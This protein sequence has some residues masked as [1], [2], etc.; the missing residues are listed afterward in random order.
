M[1]TKLTLALLFSCC[2]FYLSAQ[3]E[4]K[5]IQSKL[6][7][8]TVFLTGAELVHTATASLEKGDNE[9]RIEKL[10]PTIDRNSIKIKASNSTIISAFEFS[11][12]DLPIRKPN[13]GK[14]K[15]LRDSIDLVN[16]QL[17][18]L[19]L[20]MKIDSDLTLLL[21]KGIDKN[22]A[23]T[24]AISDLIK[25]MEYYQTKS[26][27]I[28]SRQLNNR[29]KQKKFENSIAE[30][31]QQLQKEN[32]REYEK[33]GVLH[34]RCTTPLAANTTFTISYYTPLAKWTPYYDINVA[35]TA[36]TKTER[37]KNETTKRFD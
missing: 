4:A 3:E 32:V 26:T 9:L 15:R 34:I 6:T 11:T 19:K 16:G 29:N 7:E 31:N 8:A 17:D 18:K 28:D 10:S 2:F 30:L 36:D 1:K 5:T 24:V 14:M 21:K 35:S 37:R 13:E 23:D 25:A 27:E 20:E 22:I 33:T 12:D